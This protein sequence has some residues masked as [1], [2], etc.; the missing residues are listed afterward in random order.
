[1]DKFI[2]NKSGAM[3]PVKINPSI[4][5]TVIALFGSASS[6]G[7]KID[8]NAI[9]KI[10][11]FFNCRCWKVIHDLCDLNL[12]TDPLS[13]IDFWYNDTTTLDCITGYISVYDFESLE[14]FLSSFQ[15][16]DFQKMG[17]K[18][19]SNFKRNLLNQYLEM[20]GKEEEIKEY[21]NTIE[22]SEGFFSVNYEDFVEKPL[23]K[24][25]KKLT[26]FSSKFSILVEYREEKL[27]SVLGEYKTILNNLNN[28]NKKDEDVIYDL[29]L[30]KKILNLYNS[31]FY[32]F[33]IYEY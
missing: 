23:K 12:K 27:L 21:N 9:K 26:N 33:N 32:F 11:N 25:A 20:Q 31:I 24:Y 7:L 8:E 3:I 30:K 2:K 15:S 28:K 14:S 1:M 5:Q 22:N 4:K 18:S 16:D 6:Y 17:I 10:D 29:I 19:A 13:I